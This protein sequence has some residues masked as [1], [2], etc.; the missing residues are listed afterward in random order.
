MAF[1]RWCY[2]KRPTSGEGRMRLAFLL[3]GQ[4]RGRGLLHRRN[5]VRIGG[6][7]ADVAAHVLTD[8]VVAGRMT[9][10]HAGDRRDDLP[11]TPLQKS[12]LTEESINCAA[13]SLSL[14]GV[15]GSL[16]CL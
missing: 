15:Q 2:R 14:R 9:L 13:A 12:T 6:A 5:D 7:A 4:H 16:C 1:R 11:L 3:V 8:I 10:G